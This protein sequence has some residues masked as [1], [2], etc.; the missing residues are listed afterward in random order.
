VF[1]KRGKRFR[2]AKV[3]RGKGSKVQGFREA[4]GQRGKG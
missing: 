3:Q 2:E 1:K 4:K